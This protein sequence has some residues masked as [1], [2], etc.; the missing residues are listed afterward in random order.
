[1]S[2]ITANTSVPRSAPRREAPVATTGALAWLR[3]NL[4]SGWLST[5]VTLALGYLIVRAVM[6]LVDWAFINAIWSVP[7]APNGQAQTQACREL[8]GSG[9]CWAVV[10][11]KHRF[12]LFGTYPYEQHWRP[13]LVCVLF[14]GLYV[15]S[16]MRRFWN[17]TLVP[18]WMGTL[19]V[20]GILMWGG[21][22]GL[23]Y[24]PQERW[25]GLPITLILATFGLAFAFPLSIL[26]A[27]GRRSNLPAIKVLCVLYVELIRGVPLISLLFMA[28][29]MFPLFLPEGMNIDKLLR[30]QIAFILFAGAYLAEVVRAGLQ[31]LPKGQYEAADAMGLS[32]WQKTGLIILPQA[33]RMVIPPLVNTFIG[34]FKDTSLVLII[35][36]FDLLTAGKTAIVEPAWQGFGV[37]VYVFVGLIYLVFCFA[38]SKY[39]AGLEADLNKHRRR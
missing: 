6:G 35:G 3:A 22:F 21:V 15:V 38:M 4:F 24:V 12:M 1:M 27:L 14:V 26:V 7:I 18:I 11:E 32:Y 20:I 30:A 39:S 37:E 9:A 31:G 34:F 28:S 25:G 23:P 5:A 16:A 8:Q 10:T 33:L 19:T 17:W 36:I 13:A 2:D 29:V